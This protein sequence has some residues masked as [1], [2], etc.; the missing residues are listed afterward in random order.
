MNLYVVYDNISHKH[1]KIKILYMFFSVFS[2]ITFFQFSL[3]LYSSCLSQNCYFM[4]GVLED[5]NRH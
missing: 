5:M 3:I 4:C 1:A 2:V